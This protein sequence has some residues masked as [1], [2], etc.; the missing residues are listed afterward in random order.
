MKILYAASKF[1]YGIPARGYSFEH[2]NF[3][4]S[5]VGMGHEVEYF[6]F[7]TLHQ[8]FGRDGMSRLLEQ[9]VKEVRPDLMF[10]FLYKDEFDPAVI[11]R[12]TAQGRTTTFNWFADDHWRFDDF[13][14]LWAPCFTYVS[15]TDADSLPKYR[16]IGYER[17]LLTQWGANPRFYVRKDV[18]PRYDV[19][20]VGQSYGDRP[21][22]V[23]QLHAAAIAA[24]VRGTGWKSRWWHRHARR[25]H[26]MSAGR[27]QQIAGSTRISQEEMIELFN[28]SRINLNLSASSQSGANQIKGRNFEIPACGGFQLSGVASRLEDFF[29]P[30]REVVT[31]GTTREMIE[32]IRFY[33]AHEDERRNIAEAGYARVLRDHTYERR[34][35]DLFQKMGLE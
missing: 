32:K 11:R 25:L 14:R 8:E 24:Y 29:V 19:S 3:Y 27:L 1:D 33:L 17:V 28:V 22:V 10:T 4:D 6:D 21:E 13:S 20:F 18:P 9:R 5:L 12:I 15:T 26:L 7:L 31:Y 16:A 2:Y 23:R 30:D 34:L 35:R